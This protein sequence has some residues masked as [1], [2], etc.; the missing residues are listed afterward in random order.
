V[1]GQIA[2]VLS[3][4]TLFAMSAAL[5]AVSVVLLAMVVLPGSA[6]RLAA[7]RPT[8]ANLPPEPAEQPMD[9]A[10]AAD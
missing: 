4:R 2:G 1:G 10:L 3:I 5:G 7:M 6:E 9:G 8:Q